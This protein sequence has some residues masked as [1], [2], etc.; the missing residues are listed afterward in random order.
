[1]NTTPPLYWHNLFSP[2]P[3]PAHSSLAAP[4]N[5][6][7]THISSSRRNTYITTPTPNTPDLT[8]IQIRY[9]LN[10]MAYTYT[11][12]IPT[13]FT[14]HY[15]THTLWLSHLT[16]FSLFVQCRTPY[17]VVHSLVLLKKGLMMP[18][19][20]WGGSLIINIRL[21]ASCWFLSFHPLTCFM[22]DIGVQ[23]RPVLQQAM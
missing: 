23:G 11:H 21:V 19:T 16:V 13:M 3:S 10:T 8:D 17:A 18:E 2:H 6:Y 5:T 4:N 9:Q 7:T 22:Q 12:E 1:M 20:C 14:T 15:S